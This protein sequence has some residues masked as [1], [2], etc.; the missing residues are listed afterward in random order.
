MGVFT[1]FIIALVLS[2]LQTFLG[3]YKSKLVSLIAPTIWVLCMIV[4]YFT[5]R[6]NLAI[7]IGGSIAG[8]LILSISRITSIQNHKKNREREIQNM[9]KK[10]F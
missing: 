3:R 2:I 5:D 9:K 7:L 10:D 8:I 6:I 4:F 1:F